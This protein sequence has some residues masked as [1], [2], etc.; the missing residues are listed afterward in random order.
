MLNTCNTMFTF[1]RHI[2]NPLH[3]YCRLRDIGI[4]RGSALFLCRLYEY[5]IF[6]FLFLRKENKK[7]F[8]EM[9]LDP[10]RRESE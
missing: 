1:I 10:M 6:R 9:A 5:S 4:D 7:R 8:E 3:I 2:L